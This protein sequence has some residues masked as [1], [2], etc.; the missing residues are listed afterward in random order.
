VSDLAHFDP[1]ALLEALQRHGVRFVVIGG[2][3]GRLHG[4]PRLTRDLDICYARAAADLDRLAAALAELHVTLR[5]APPDLPFRPDARTL[6]SGLNFTFD[7]PFGPFDC[8]GEASGHTYEILS[9]NAEHGDL[10]G[11]DILVTSLDDL[12]RMKR[13]SGRPQDLADLETLGKLR[14]VREERGLFGLAEPGSG[15]KPPA[16]AASRLRPARPRRPVKRS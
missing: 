14:D 2:I 9:P 7:T 11:L 16:K 4:S 13:A 12:M 15:R 10:E 3:A 6:R 8:L 5:G 1:R